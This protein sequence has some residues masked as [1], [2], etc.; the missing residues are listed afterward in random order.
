MGRHRPQKS[1]DRHV[2]GRST[3]QQQ[4]HRPTVPGGDPQV[5]PPGADQPV[6]ELPAPLGRPGAHEGLEIRIGPQQLRQQHPA[7]P[8]GVGGERP[9]QPP[10]EGRGLP[11]APEA[12]MQGAPAGEP[13]AGEQG[14]SGHERAMTT[15]PVSA[16]SCPRHGPGAAGRI[17]AIAHQTCHGRARTIAPPLAQLALSADLSLV[18]V[19]AGR[20]LDRTAARLKPPERWKPP[21]RLSDQPGRRPRSGTLSRRRHRPGPGRKSP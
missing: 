11:M 16:T 5:R 13:Q 12:E 2:N 17:R 19:A 9:P 21:E 10:G 20:L 7:G 3:G 6:V 14:G 15:L 18:V 1:L 4:T 8:A